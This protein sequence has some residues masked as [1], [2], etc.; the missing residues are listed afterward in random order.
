M[1]CSF[2]QLSSLHTTEIFGIPPFPSFF[3]LCAIL[4]T[5]SFKGSLQLSLISLY[6]GCP[7][8]PL[9]QGPQFCPKAGAL[10]TSHSGFPHGL[11]CVHTPHFHHQYF[12]SD[13]QSVNLLNSTGR[14]SRE[15]MGY[16]YN[17]RC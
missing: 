12:L 14:I 17:A 9:Y 16:C 7:L 6:H 15:D 1:L 11:G 4:P 13:I 2:C 8:V 5:P 3:L 10:C